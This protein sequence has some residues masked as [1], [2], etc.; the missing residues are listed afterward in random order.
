M[1][2]YGLAGPHQ[3]WVV[4]GCW[5]VELGVGLAEADRVNDRVTDR[6]KDKDRHWGVGVKGEASW[7]RSHGDRDACVVNSH[8]DGNGMAVFCE[9]D[10][11][12]A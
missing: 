3:V 8:S 7:L 5:A 2:G 1:L 12:H 10:T 4:L 6:Y 11:P 9:W